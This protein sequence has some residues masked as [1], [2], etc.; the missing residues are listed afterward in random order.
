VGVK[1]TINHSPET[2]A[3]LIEELAKLLWVME[4]RGYI[5][6]EFDRDQDD[7]LNLRAK[8]R[9]AVQRARERMGC[10]LSTSKEPNNSPEWRLECEAR[11]VMKW[12]RLT[13]EAYYK[14]ITGTGKRGELRRDELINEVNRLRRIAREAQGME[15]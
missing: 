12:D 2:D 11:H 9:L 7:V 13:R 5:Q 1:L 15:I 3:A 10:P 14:A 4:R 8:A 6:S